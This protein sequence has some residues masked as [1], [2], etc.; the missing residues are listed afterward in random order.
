M[1]SGSRRVFRY[2]STHEKD[3]P[4]GSI[5]RRMEL[6]RT[7]HARP[8][9]TRT[10]QD[11]Q[12]SRDP[13]R[14]L[15]PPENRPPVVAPLAPRLPQVAHRL[16]VLQQMAYRRHL[17]EDQPC[18]PRTPQGALEARSPA[19][20]AGVVDSRSLK[21]TALGGEERGFDAGK[22]VKGRLSAPYRWTPKASCS[23]GEGPQRQGHGLGGHQNA[24]TAGE[25]AL[26]P[27]AASVVGGGLPRR[28]EDKGAETGYR[29]PWAGAWSSSSAR[30]S[31][32]PK[33]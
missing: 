28:G 15:L 3:I 1:K 10:A 4:Y 6:H 31:P 17:A 32:P 26:C 8:R 9:G 30:K 33:G 5:R 23:Q 18:T 2:S 27:S 11:P 16:L 12:P 19:Q 24:A 20:S 7:P 14:P 29:R 25:R 21:S 13:R 22:K